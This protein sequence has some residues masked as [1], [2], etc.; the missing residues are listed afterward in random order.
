MEDI[1]QRIITLVKKKMQEQ[2]A[3]DRDAYKSLVEESVEYYK[4]KGEITEDDNIEFIEDRLME[5]WPSIQESISQ[6]Y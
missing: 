6:K 5:M 1:I 2:G 4:V 3:Y